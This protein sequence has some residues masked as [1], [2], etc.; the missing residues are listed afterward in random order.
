MV[1]LFSLTLVY[2]DL[3]YEVDWKYGDRDISENG[4]VFPRSIDGEAGWRTAIFQIHKP[5]H[6]LNVINNNNY[7]RKSVRQFWMTKVIP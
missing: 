3:C 1:L 6:L 5:I 2:Q 4:S 7:K